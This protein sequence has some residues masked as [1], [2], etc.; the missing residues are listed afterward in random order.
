M[1]VLILSCLLHLLAYSTIAV[2]A[3]GTKLELN[4]VTS[5]LA[6]SGAFQLPE[7]TAPLSVSVALC[8]DSYAS[9]P[10]MYV[11]NG[12]DAEEIEVKVVNGIGSFIGVATMLRLESSQDVEIGVSDN[13]KMVS[14]SL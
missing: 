9:L 3:Q 1:L 12:T 13:G 6:S 8:A 2:Q 5:F 10:R 14:L 11:S 4:H 7:S